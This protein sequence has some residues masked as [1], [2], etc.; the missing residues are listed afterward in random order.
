M[1]V[2]KPN[3]WC[4]YTLTHLNIIYWVPMSLVCPDSII[5][6]STS[7][8]RV[9]SPVHKQNEILHQVIIQATR[10]ALPS[11]HH[12]NCLCSM[13]CKSVYSQCKVNVI[14]PHLGTSPAKRVLARKWPDYPGRIGNTRLGGG[15]GEYLITWNLCASASELN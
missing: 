9:S 3:F 1:F 15:G 6:I 8:P 4:L 12:E 7:G 10:Q 14:V 5:S 2:T 11:A 13:V